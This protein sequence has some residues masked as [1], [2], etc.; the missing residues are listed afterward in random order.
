MRK[1]NQRKMKKINNFLKIKNSIIGNAYHRQNQGSIPSKIENYM[2]K[3]PED[4]ITNITTTIQTLRKQDEQ[5]INVNDHQS[6]LHFSCGNTIEVKGNSLKFSINN[7]L[8]NMKSESMMNLQPFKH[9]KNDNKSKAQTIKNKDVINEKNSSNLFDKIKEKL[10]KN[11]KMNKSNKNNNNKENKALTFSREDRYD[12]I[13]YRKELIDK[14][15]PGP[16]EYN[17]EEHSIN[18]PLRYS[19]LFKNNTTF[20]L[21]QFKSKNNKI[22]PGSYDNLKQKIIN[23]GKFSTL[24]K[25][26]L[27]KNNNE[28]N[29]LGPGCFDLPGGITVREKNKKNYYFMVGHE[30]KEN[31][32][33]KYGIERAQIIKSYKDLNKYGEFKVKPRWSNKEKTKNFN[34]D[35]IKNNLK[36]KIKE[37]TLKGN[38]IDYIGNYNSN[39][40]NNL[41]TRQDMYYWAKNIKDEILAK[42]TGMKKGAYSFS[43]RPKSN[44]KKNHVPGPSYY[45]PENILKGIILKKEFNSNLQLNWI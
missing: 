7:T 15:Y 13:F 4:S 43:R 35:W 34:N 8:K 23:G 5:N 2:F 1:E 21:L 17:I 32:E 11:I 39:S 38:I 31:L 24:K 18:C 6:S 3:L 30:K 14:Y 19:S 12:N 16:G 41:T 40:M 28:N 44:I 25:V 37:E 26:N 22:G 33:K 9:S 27:F 45:E 20:P 36:R 10:I 42:K 29:N